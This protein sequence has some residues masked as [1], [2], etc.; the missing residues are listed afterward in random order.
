LILLPTGALF[1][2]TGG[3]DMPILAL[4][5]LAVVFM[6]RRAAWST[7]IT[8]GVAAAMKLTA[9]P[10]ALGAM[11][12]TRDKN[13]RPAWPH[14]LIASAVVV[15]VTATPYAL[16]APVAFLSNV[17]SF[18]LGISGVASP[19]ASALP[20]HILTTWWPVLRHVILPVVFVVGGYFAARFVKQSWPLSLDTMLRFLSV[21]SLVVICAA[22]ATRVGYIIYPIDFAVWAWALKVVVPVPAEPVLN[23]A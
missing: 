14:V 5:L 2:A 18:P 7:G 1:L 11:L 22:S 6:Q 8:I 19:A 23:A 15:G 3:D 17:V 21:S 9:W 20:G 16:K 4:M 13:G 12:V 10:F